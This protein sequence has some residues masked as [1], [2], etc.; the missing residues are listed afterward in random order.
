[1]TKLA[2]LV[3]ILLI[4]SLIHSQE[5]EWIQTESVITEITVHQGKIKRETATVK[6]NLESGEETL[7][8]VELYRIPFIGSM[9][10]IGDKISIHYNKNNPG[11][12]ETV[13]GK[14]LFDYGMYILIFLGIVFSI[15]PFLKKGKNNNLETDTNR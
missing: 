4:P 7:G 12:I 3:I 13:L 11:L 8:S 2:Y 5:G 15:R 6:F 1:M 10:S 14:F 9:K